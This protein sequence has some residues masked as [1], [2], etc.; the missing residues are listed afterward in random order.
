MIINGNLKFHTLGSGELQNAI[1]ERLASAPGTTVAGRLYYNTATNTYCYYNGSDWVCFATGGNTGD[2]QTEIDNIETTIGG[3]INNDGTFNAGG[4]TGATYITSPTSIT[5]AIMQLDSAINSNNTLAELDDVQFG[6]LVDNDILQY[7][8]VAQKWE[9]VAIGSASGVQPYDAGLSALAAAGTG[10]VAMDGNNAYFRTLTAPAEGITVTNGN[11]VADN[12]TLALANDL[13]AVEGLTSTGFG[14]RTAADTWATRTIE[15]T[16]GNIVVTG[17]SGATANPVVNLQSLTIPTTAG[18]FLKF[19]YDVY[20]RVTSVLAVAESD[21]TALVDDVY[22]NISGDTMTGNLTMNGGTVTGLPTPVGDTDAA[23]KAYVDALTAGL[24]WKDAARVA[25]T[26]NVDLTTGGLL[27]VDGVTVAD[28]DRVLVLN[29]T[30]PAQ[31]GI[32]IA[33]SSAWTRA[34]DMDAAAEFDGAAIFVQEGSTYQSTGW[35]QVNTVATVGTD[36]VSWSQFSGGSIYTWGTGL[37]ATGN[38]INVG[39]GAGIYEM[40]TDEV[41]VDAYSPA[42]MALSFSVAGVRDDTPPTDGQLSLFASATGGVEGGIGNAATELALDFVGMPTKSAVAEGEDFVAFYNVDATDHETITFSELFQDLD[43]P[44]GITGTGLIARTGADAY[45]SRTITVDGAGAKDGLTIQNGDGI[46]GNPTIGL[47]ITGTPASD[48]LDGDEEFIVYNPDQ[49]GGAANAKTTLSAISTF[50]QS[51]T[52]LDELSDVVITSGADGEA[53]VFN[54]TNWV[55]QKIYHL[56]TQGTDSAS[57]TVTH[58]IGQQYCNV[59]VVDASDEVIIPQSITFTS[60]TAL[61]ITF[62]TAIQGKA[63]VMGVA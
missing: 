48:T 36:A 16:A 58:D 39:L 22:V 13:G 2:L 47:D 61:T 28:G 3:A 45:A 32:Y 43:V 25:T 44:Y 60:T 49:T 9:N 63:V 18:S 41:G 59:T 37:S 8:S 54:G 10:L 6:T 14:V 57:W 7:N 29:Q 55:N 20:G 27:T 51:D 42:T 52:T 33:H 50:V 23:N 38:T 62:N 56:H 24:S 21:I 30:A 11:G 26:G 4:F 34:T 15:G 35:T 40:P 12:P 46:G 31:N 19:D 17:G 5:N 53:L 1:I